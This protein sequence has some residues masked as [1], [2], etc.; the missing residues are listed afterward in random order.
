[1]QEQK[2]YGRREGAVG[3]LV[4]NNPAKLNAVSLDMWDAFVGILKSTPTAHVVDQ[5]RREVGLASLNIAYQLFE[6][7][8]TVDSQAA[9]APLVARSPAMAAPRTGAGRAWR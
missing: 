3:H 6:G 4:F 5:Y 9:L 1:M 2:I 8:T 7:V